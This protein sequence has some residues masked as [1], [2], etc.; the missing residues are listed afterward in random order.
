MSHGPL[1][2]L[3]GPAGSGKTTLVRR[4]LAEDPHPLR[5]S[6]SVTTR[7]PREGEVDGRDYHFWTRQ[8]FEEGVRAGAFLE[9]AEVHGRDYYGTLRREVDDYTPRGIGVILVID[10]QGAAQVRTVRPD[11]VSVFLLASSLEVYEQRLRQRGT[12]DEA[13]IARRLETAKRELEHVGDYQYQV[14]ND[15]LDDAVVQFRAVI[16]HYF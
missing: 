9:T 15:D 4:V 5:V 13:T 12:E 7:R 3:S 6:V 2:I 8:R 11:A 1:I 10:V 14:V 16:A